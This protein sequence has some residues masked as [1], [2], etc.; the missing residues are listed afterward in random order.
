MRVPSVERCHRWRQFLTMNSTARTSHSLPAYYRARR[1]PRD[2][3]ES[4]APRRRMAGLAGLSLVCGLAIQPNLVPL[5]AQTP[6]G[7]ISGMVVNATTQKVLERAVV[8]VEGTNLSAITEADGRFRLVGVPAGPRSVAAN[9]TGL[10][11]SRATV[12]VVAGT[13]AT[14]DFALK[15]G[16]V[17]Q[18]TAFR[19]A[20]EPE[21][22]AYAI[23]QQ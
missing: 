3:K 13:V 11:E 4:C 12:N 6:T 18:L 16:D 17:V 10:E 23:Q 1:A 8:T 22:N 21:G 14:A 5:H 7:T 9:Y 20:G 15:L 2:D 19:V